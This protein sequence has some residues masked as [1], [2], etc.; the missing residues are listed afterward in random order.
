MNYLL[1]NIEESTNAGC[2]QYDSL[3]HSFF[4]TETACAVLGIKF[5]FRLC[6]DKFAELFQCDDD[7]HKKTLENYFKNN[8]KFTI[9]LSLKNLESKSSPVKIILEGRPLPP[10]KDVEGSDG[11]FKSVVPSS[12]G[13]GDVFPTIENFQEQLKLLGS[14]TASIAHDLSNPLTVVG[15]NI[16]MLGRALDKPEKLVKVHHDLKRGLDKLELLVK[17]IKAFSESTTNDD[18]SD[19]DVSVIIQEIECLYGPILTSKKIDISFSLDQEQLKVHCIKIKIIEALGQLIKNST[20][21]IIKSRNSER[22]IKIDISNEF[23]H[24]KIQISDSGNGLDKSTLSLLKNNL[25]T[26]NQINNKLGLNLVKQYITESEGTFD[27]EQIGDQECIVLT[28]PTPK[29]AA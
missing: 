14:R 5:K 15:A 22:W 19:I 4:L 12:N 13:T 28:V 6:F 20:H 24:V 10:A 18:Y 17:Q 16:R 23:D 7:N 3:T 8:S 11:V 21:A 27:V 29:K 25:N 26:P 9:T 2:W 1:Q